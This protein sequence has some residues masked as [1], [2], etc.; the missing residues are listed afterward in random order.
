MIKHRQLEAKLF[1]TF[2]LHRVEYFDEMWNELSNLH[3]TRYLTGIWDSN[4]I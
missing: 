4:I 3:P 1:M 2:P